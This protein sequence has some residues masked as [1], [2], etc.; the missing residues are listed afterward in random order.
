M[1]KLEIGQKIR[2]LR[3]ARGYSQYQLGSLVGLS[4]KAV[5]KWETGKALPERSVCSKLS[6]LLGFDF[7]LMINDNLTPDEAE[8]LVNAQREALWKKA[9]KRM[10][11]I[12]GEDPPLAISNRFILERNMMR[13]SDSII[14]Y[15]VLGELC[16]RAR[17][18][19]ARFE[20]FGTSS[21]TAWLLGATRLNPAEPHRYCKKCRR[22]EFHPEVLSGWDL[23]PEI[24]ECGTRM[25]ND[26]QGI[27]AEMCILGEHS[28]YEF[29]RCNLDEEFMKE[30]EE[31]ILTYG[32]RFFAMEQYRQKGE[33]TFETD[34]ETGLPVT[35]PVTGKKIPIRSLPI[36]VLLFRSKKKPTAR[37]PDKV[38]NI[39]EVLYQNGSLGAPAIVLLGGFHEPYYP[40]RPTVFPA[41]PEELTRPEVL[42]RALRNWWAYLPSFMETHSR[43]DKVP[44]P[45]PYIRSL[46]F[47]KFVSMLCA[48]H[49][50][51]MGS[52]PEELAEKTGFADWTELPY[53]H[54]DL[55]KMICRHTAYPGYMS[56]AAGEILNRITRGKYLQSITPG[57]R[58]TFRELNLPEW[59]ETY[60]GSI[61]NLAS[62]SECSELAIHLLEDA[63]Q[64]IREE[65]EHKRR[66]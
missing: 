43:M 2:E 20:A 1:D 41:G 9:E 51:Y 44:D 28:P 21:F 30:A 58:K 36:C 32:E 25:T 19:Q 39:A 17:E 56:G 45:E 5:S 13:H 64:K 49:C 12:Y 4:D 55:W 42:E 65:Q 8:A 66:Y 50:T 61:F 29:I 38:P 18:R 15:D 52:G 11:E 63:R 46:S 22:I 24:C 10:K 26:G 27:P 33:E 60:A 54:A 31:I 62:R 35:D 14:L 40:G 47:G 59:F 3:T 16:R 53:S 37:K 34:P 23:L 6:G 57:D 48:A 7:E